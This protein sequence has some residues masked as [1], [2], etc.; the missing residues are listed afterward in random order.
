MNPLAP[1]YQEWLRRQAQQQPQLDA[2]GLPFLERAA[3]IPV[4]DGF[5]RDVITYPDGRVVRSD[6]Q[7]NLVVNTFAE[8]VAQLVMG[9]GVGTGPNATYLGVTYM[10]LGT[11]NSS[12]DTSG[13][14]APNLTDTQL[15]AEPS[16]GNFRKLCTAQMVDS[17]GNVTASLTNRVLCSTT[18]NAG[19]ANG[20]LREWGLFGGNA[21]ATANSGLMIDHVTHPLIDKSSLSNDF[22]LTRQVTLIF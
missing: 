19:E 10:A 12:W 21:T 15:V 16:T 18:F 6:W 9:N 13:P 8:L 17:N 20:K 3:V 1:L 14:A 4:V 11:G 22:A 5:W 2:A 7:H